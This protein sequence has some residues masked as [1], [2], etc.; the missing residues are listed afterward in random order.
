MT[1]EKI[2]KEF[3]E[4]YSKTYHNVLKFIVCKCQN[5]E[6]VNDLV[7][8]TYIELYKKLLKDEQVDNEISYLIGI[9]KNKLKKHY[10]L[11][12]RFKI[13]SLNNDDKE[14]D[15]L[16]QI[17]DDVDIE[18]MVLKNIDIDRVWNL[19]KKKNINI[20]KIFYLYYS[21]DLTIKEIA[22]ELALS[23]SYVKNSL[24]RTLKELQNILRKDEKNV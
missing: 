12:S 18:K 9:A 23:E 10:N 13:V 21:Q 16:S 19:L 15:I 8:E 17:P 6:D 7:Q 2:S 20:Q 14:K 4:I 1:R 11:F 22:K 24:Y 5:I 3:D